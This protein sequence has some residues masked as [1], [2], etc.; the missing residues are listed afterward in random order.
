VWASS[1]DGVRVDGVVQLRSGP[2]QPPP[3]LKTY[4]SL[5]HLAW[6]RA[7][8]ETRL[9]LIDQAEA[10]MKSGSNSNLILRGVVLPVN[11]L[12]IPMQVLEAVGKKVPDLNKE[13]VFIYNAD[14]SDQEGALQIGEDASYIAWACAGSWAVSGLLFMIARVLKRRDVRLK[15]EFRRV[16]MGVQPSQEFAHSS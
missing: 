10:R 7:H 5:D 14:W 9:A 4:D 3:G 11:Q 1:G 13:F 16:F 8:N 12:D 2:V 15:E 6:F